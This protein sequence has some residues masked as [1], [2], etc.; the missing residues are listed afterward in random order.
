VAVDLIVLKAASNQKGYKAVKGRLHNFRV[1]VAVTQALS[2]FTCQLEIS[3][4]PTYATD[5]A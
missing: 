1:G 4:V 3:G 2:T 5:I